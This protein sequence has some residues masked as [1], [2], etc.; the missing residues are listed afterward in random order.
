[1]SNKP[2]NNAAP[3]IALKI[4]RAP[5]WPFATMIVLEQAIST[6]VERRT[7]QEL[8]PPDVGRIQPLYRG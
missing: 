3:K 2:I 7:V 4:K 6:L 1:M 5:V 8:S